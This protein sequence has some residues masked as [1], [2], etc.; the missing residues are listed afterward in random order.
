MANK[1]LIGIDI[2]LEW[3]ELFKQGFPLSNV[4][5]AKINSLL[6]KIDEVCV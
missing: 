6:L 1:I 2:L 4:I 3:R 5:E